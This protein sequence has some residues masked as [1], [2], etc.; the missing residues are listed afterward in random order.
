MRKHGKTHSTIRR[1]YHYLRQN[2]AVLLP[3]EDYARQLQDFAGDRG[4]VIIYEKAG[5][6][7]KAQRKEDEA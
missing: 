3:N 7:I 6:M 4:I 5:T 1:A 2:E